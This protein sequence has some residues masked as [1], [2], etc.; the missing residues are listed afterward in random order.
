MRRWPIMAFRPM[1]AF[2]KDHGAEAQGILPTSFSSSRSSFS[3]QSLGLA[4]HR[5][6]VAAAT[7]FLIVGGILLFLGA[8]SLQGA[9]RGSSSDSIGQASADIV[10]DVS[11]AAAGR[12]TAL[13]DVTRLIVVAGHTVYL[14]AR[15]ESADLRQEQNWFLEPHQ[16]GQLDTFLAH[17]RRGVELAANDS[18]ALLL[19]S[20]GETRP[21]VGPRSE[22]ASYWLAA[23]AF[24]W[25]GH[26]ASAMNR[27]HAEEYARDS[28]ENLLF[29]VC[30]FRQLTGRY[31][32]HV[33]VVSF[34]F[35][36]TRF[37]R[38]H[39]RALRFPAKSFDYVGV[40]PPLSSGFRDA[41]VE[42]ELT[43]A[44]H[45]FREDPYGCRLVRLTSKRISRNPLIRF[46][47]YPQGCPELSGLFNYCGGETFS[48]TLPWDR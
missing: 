17:I 19:F 44:L 22:G 12:P 33:T 16:G 35:K 40:D 14:G 39:R 34:E 48:G 5:A 45:P 25:F 1:M 20:G 21:G 26:R 2:S 43:G 31:P 9:Q 46:H 11:A 30:R 28:F 23:E 47:P 24:D 38:V 18:R 41:L 37:E 13:K 10:L 6:L 4:L 8:S 36:R 7:G 15:W 3:A 32:K 29:S 27:T 42:R